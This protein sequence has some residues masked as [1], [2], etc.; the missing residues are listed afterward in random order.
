MLDPG[1]LWI[2]SPQEFAAGFCIALLGGFVRGLTGFGSGLIMVPLFSMLWGPVEAIG[3]MV[4]L[5]FLT[6]FQVLLPALRVARLREAA[7]LLAGSTLFTPVGVALLVSLDPGLV[8]KI[9]ALVIL[10]LTGVMLAGWS[11]RGQRGPVQG[12]VVGGLTG[13]VNGV[14]GAGGPITVVYVMAEKTHAEL[15]RASIILA[16]GLSAF[17][18]IFS[19]VAAD[20]VGK[21]TL[22]HVAAFILPTIAGTWFGAWLFARLPSGLYRQIVLWFL[23]VI[24]VSLLL[25]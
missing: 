7:P 20:A 24:S 12:F 8:K 15:Q 10:T 14:A 13:F 22:I 21:R 9:I 3:A 25:K 1:S 19:L 5:G 18:T 4:G 2:Y 16:M 17:M 11:W 6:L 23:V